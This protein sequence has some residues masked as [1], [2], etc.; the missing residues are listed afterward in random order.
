MSFFR[1]PILKDIHERL[2]LQLV[3]I[4]DIA[5]NFPVYLLSKNSDNMYVFLIFGVSKAPYKSA[6]AQTKYVASR[7]N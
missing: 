1:T 7:T 5:C 6:V 2:L 3:Q 4:S